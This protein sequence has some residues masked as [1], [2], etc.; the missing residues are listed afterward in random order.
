MAW[1]TQPMTAPQSPRHPRGERD[2]R[3]TSWCRAHADGDEAGPHPVHRRTRRRTR[4]RGLRTPRGLGVRLHPRPRTLRTQRIKVVSGILSVWGRTPAT[5]AMS[6]ATLHQISGGRYVLGLGAST[7]ALVKGFHGIPYA[8]PAAKLRDVTRMFAR[9]SRAS[10][11]A[12]TASRGR[13]RLGRPPVPDL[14]I[15][16]AAL[17]RSKG[18]WRRRRSCRTGVISS[19][20]RS[21]ARAWAIWLGETGHGGHVHG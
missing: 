5:L 11:L 8:N 3:S 4:I 15:W 2:D 21:R 7:G 17:A 10:G 12:S 20:S 16:L 18:S 19:S 13:G 6:A 9:C 1:A 14:P